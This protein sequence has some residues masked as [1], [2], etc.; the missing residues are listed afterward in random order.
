M[1][2]EKVACKSVRPSEELRAEQGG[3]IV[4]DAALYL[5]A[6]WHLYL[7]K[8]SFDSLPHTVLQITF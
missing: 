4:H 8:L 3:H 2:Q 5:P 7:P 1:G 6:K